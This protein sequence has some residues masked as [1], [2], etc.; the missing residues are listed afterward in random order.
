MA[1]SGMRPASVAA[2]ASVH[3]SD[4]PSRK[5]TPAPTLRVVDAIA[6]IIGTVVGAGIFRTPSLV[7][8]NASSEEMAL[9]AWVAGGAISLVGALCYAELTTTFPH[10]GGDYHYLTRAFGRWLAFLF[11]WAR[12]T[13]IQTGSI[14]LLAFVIGD[15]AARLVP[16]G[17]AGPAVYAALTIAGVTA[18]NIVGTRQSKRTQNVLTAAELLGLVTIIGAGLF[19]PAAQGL[20]AAPPSGSITT[21]QIGLVMVFVLLTYGGWNE[22]AYISAEVRGA[23]RNMAGILVVSIGIIAALYVAVNWAYLRGLGLEGMAR[24][25]TVGADLLQRVTGN[26]GAHLVSVLILV[27]TLTSMNA[28]VFTGARAAYALGRDHRAFAFLGR[29]NRRAGTPINALLV[30]AAIALSLVTIAGVRRHGFET[31]VEYTAPVFWLFFLLTGMSL[32]LLRRREPR[33]ARPF[34]VPLYPLTPL[35]FC[36]TSAY[37]LYA[38]LVHTGAGAVWGVAVLAVGAGVLVLMRRREGEP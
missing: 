24:S 32:F 15:Y 33:A 3:A 2:R 7:A 38:S 8:A 36:V 12:I 26:L 28:A 20:G 9:L 21:S 37:L 1:V 34:R 30:Q 18:I 23:R 35:V 27:C 19:A 6:L 17:S 10:S 4:A 11:G 29:W 22:A 5:D 25:T 14:A 13:V 16:L 31:L